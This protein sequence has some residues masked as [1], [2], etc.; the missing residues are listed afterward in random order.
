MSKK[1]RA[2]KNES[3]LWDKYYAKQNI[4]WKSSGL[5]KHIN[6]FIRKYAVGN[7][8][9]EIG[10]GSGEDIPGLI[11]LKLNYT[12]LDISKESILQCKDKY[13]GLKFHAYNILSTDGSNL[14]KNKIKYSIIYD[15]GVFHNLKGDKQREKFAKKINNLL[16]RKGI[17]VSVSGSADDL[18]KGGVHGAI[19][20]QNYCVPIENYFEILEVKKSVYGL[21]DQKNDFNA[22]YCIARK[23][24]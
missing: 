19:F 24:S 2:I 15:K 17:W 6:T 13:K 16:A 22:W 18:E 8:I 23:R 14:F 7:K 12:G 1:T 20:L 9:L 4:P 10:C 3:S 11:K 21:V 5:N